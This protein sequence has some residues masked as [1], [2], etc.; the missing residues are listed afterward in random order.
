M[1]GRV[2]E[3]LVLHRLLQFSGAGCGQVAVI[4]GDAGIGKTRLCGQLLAAARDQRFVALSGRCGDR[5][6]FLPYLPFVEAIG[7]H[8]ADGDTAKLRATL[9]PMCRELP[10]LFPRLDARRATG[11]DLDAPESH[12]RLYEEV[13]GLLSALAGDSGLLLV[14]E[15]LQWS[16]RSTLQ[17]F[18]YLARRLRTQRIMLVGTYRTDEV[19]PQHPLQVHVRGWARTGTLIRMAPLDPD[20]VG[21]LARDIMG[22]E[23]PEELSRLLHSRSGGNPFVAEELLKA[24]RHRGGVEALADLGLPATLREATLARVHAMDGEQ[25]RVLRLASVLGTSFDRMTLLEVAG[26]D[27]AALQAGL[28]SCQDAQLLEVDADAPRRLRFRHATIREAV[29]D[30]LERE[31]AAEI[32]AR[33]AA[34]LQRV[35]GPSAEVARHLVAARRPEE[36]VPWYRWAAEE[37]SAK[38]AHRDAADFL[39]YALVHAREPLLTA[40]IRC[41][42]G[43]ARLQ[44]GDERGAEGPL[45]EGIR[46]LE[47]MGEHTLAAS[48]RLALARVRCQLSRVDE[49]QADCEAALA[50]LQGHEPSAGLADAYLRLAVGLMDAGRPVALLARHAMRIGERLGEHSIVLRARAIMAPEYLYRG[51]VQKGLEMLDVTGEEALRLGLDD[52]ADR[53]TFHAV[54]HHAQLDAVGARK[55]LHRLRAAR[56]YADTTAIQ[57]AAEAHHDAIVGSYA[58]ALEHLERALVLFRTQR[59]RSWRRWVEAQMAI[60]HARLG[61]LDEARRWQPQS[62]EPLVHRAVAAAL[63]GLDLGEPDRGRAVVRLAHSPERVPVTLHAMVTDLAVAVLVALDEP[64]EARRVAA[65]LPAAGPEVTDRHFRLMVDARV[66]LTG[67]D[68]PRA[69]GL[70]REAAAELG[71]IGCEDYERDARLLLVDTLDRLGDRLEGRAQLM[72]VIEGARHRGSVLQEQ[73]ARARR[74]SGLTLRE[75]EVA[76]LVAD[77][78]TD[79]DIARRLGIST[80]TAEAH[81]ANIRTK[82]GALNRA[83]VAAWVASRTVLT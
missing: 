67:E 31:H 52:L 22:V 23:L 10:R 1:V 78:L 75:R 69:A 72:R 33:A 70:L 20:Q 35:D 26:A 82:L 4:A 65:A 43:A 39:R 56:G 61:R 47:A 9:G 79:P 19:G 8:L 58:V 18:A 74:L 5:E 59:A 7:D 60:V 49:A 81:V 30:E 37:A 71:R 13:L 45:V 25:L 11:G 55:R 46:A 76:R 38:Q 57:A 16:D 6:Q 80:R 44:A 15:D 48:H 28:R 34:A 24:A 77:G 21:E 36:A 53:A 27:R 32:H 2:D 3:V 62:G 73:R 14:V 54:I 51:A 68:L 41:E 83:Q 50:A 17:L 12:Q 66:A 29:Y 42:L 64:V 63:V 40:R